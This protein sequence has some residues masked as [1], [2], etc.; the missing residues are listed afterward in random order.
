MALW[1]N[2]GRNEKVDD[3]VLMVLSKTR[4]ARLIEDADRART[5]DLARMI[6]ITVVVIY[7]LVGFLDIISTNLAIGLGKGEEANPFLRAMMDQFG[8]GW[9]WEY[10]HR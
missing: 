6:A 2:F 1:R 7:N 5:S 9:I 3:L 8:A 4:R 10:W